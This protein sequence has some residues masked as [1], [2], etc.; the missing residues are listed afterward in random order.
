MKRILSVVVILG[1]LFLSTACGTRSG[2]D[3]PPVQQPVQLT[4]ERRLY[5]SAMFT[6]KVVVIDLDSLAIEAEQR[7]GET[8]YGLAVDRAGNQLLAA[9]SLSN[10][11][12]CLDLTTLETKAVIAVDRLPAYI[13]IDEEKRRA[14]VG[15]SGS[16]TVSVIDLDAH[17][18]IDRIQVGKAPVN[19]ALLPDR[20]L[21][22]TLH[23]E[24]TMAMIDLDNLEVVSRHPI[25][26]NAVGLAFD[27]RQEL[28]YTG[29]HGLLEDNNIVRIHP[30]RDPD[31]VG[32][33][34]TPLMPIY[35]ELTPDGSKLLSLH[36]R[37]NQLFVID[38]ATGVMLGEMNAGKSPFST[39]IWDD[40][41]M[42]AVA[43]MD[44]N[45]VQIVDLEHFDTVKFIKVLEGPACMVVLD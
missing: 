24:G 44:S 19:L 21:A 27:S 12:W 28:I 43:N 22:V 23:D 11:V 33:L 37:I 29:G 40:G 2:G 18:E 14:Y 42:A 31:N 39:A 5:V 36:H 7:V 1:C 41:R 10:E 4:S 3:A 15:N 30:L 35:L 8:P 9:C 16:D 26:G 20:R 34:E 6:D 45:E 38:P 25:A 13:T 17:R 32:Q